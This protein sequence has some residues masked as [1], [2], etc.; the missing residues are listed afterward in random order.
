MKKCL[1]ADN[2]LFYLQFFSD[3]LAG[4]GYEVIT[5]SDGL[6]AL[7]IARKEKIDLFLLDFVMPKVDGVR[8]AKYLRQINHYKDTPIILITA[9]ALESVTM[10]ESDAYID[11]YVA[12][13]PFDKMKE[14]FNEILPHIDSLKNKKSKGVIGLENIY[15][16]QIVKELL[17]TELNYSVIFQS[18][19]E[20]ILELDE[21]GVAV[22]ANK[23]FCQIINKKEH[24]VIGHTLN[25][26][27]DF[28]KK[29]ELRE[30]YNNLKKLSSA[31]RETAVCEI[32]E[33]TV[34]CSF[35]NIPSSSN[36]TG[37]SFVILQDVTSI[38]SKVMQISSLFNITQAFL[39]NL[40]YKD[41]LQYVLYE[42]RRLVNATNISLLFACDGI[43][44]G[45]RI[46]AF[47]RKAL[48]S[49]KKKIT[50]WV[51]KIEE[52]KKSG[53][54]NV[55][56]VAKLNKIKFDN[57]P[58]LWL[59]MVFRNT[60]LG[61]LIG[62]KSSNTEFDEEEIKFFEAVGNQLSVYIANE[63]FFN[64]Y[65]S[66]KAIT[67]DD[68]QGAEVITENMIEKINYLKWADRNRKNI[69]KII[70]EDI[71]RC[72]SNLGCSISLI[73]GEKNQKISS[74]LNNIKGC[75]ATMIS[76][77][78]AMSVLN[79]VGLEEESDFHIFSMDMLIKNLKSLPELEKVLFP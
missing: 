22:F 75:Y 19:V 44:K 60:F 77:K 6:I 3:V 27:L 61:T 71:N 41:V 21:K 47:E 59:P 56:T 11:I 79:K 38:K 45:G 66:N 29:P 18:L 39:S 31:R 78:D 55:K 24:E 7:D 65:V 1:V 43:F 23:S 14:T 67:V 16:R 17:V 73:E 53:L 28:E 54:I 32:G 20:G 30:A 10:N 57:M 46:T 68:S 36:K 40:P 50:F 25:D 62:F 33:K 15:P 70:T 52:W 69:S 34:H 12:K 4:H 76:L 74:I 42:L 5:A 51:N 49:E 72:L 48:E 9:A 64:R 8:L 58:I 26:I 2:N 37:G 63:E 35:Y 13:A